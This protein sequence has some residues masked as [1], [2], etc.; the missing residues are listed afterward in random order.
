MT[1]NLLTLTQAAERLG[2]D[3]PRAGRWLKLTVLER[4]RQVGRHILVRHGK[5]DAIRPRYLV[6]MST[7]RR[8]CPDMFDGRDDV[9][10]AAAALNR[11]TH[12]RLSA[13]DEHLLEIDAR[14]KE[15][16]DQLKLRGLLGKTKTG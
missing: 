13:L 3:R 10:R 8:W 5:Q 9:V 1:S 4:E 14:L 16:A 11:G 12:D 6:N 7:L 2:I 15:L